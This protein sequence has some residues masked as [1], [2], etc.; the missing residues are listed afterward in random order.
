MTVSEIRRAGTKVGYSDQLDNN[1]KASNQKGSYARDNRVILPKS[2]NRRQSLP[3][4]HSGCISREGDIEL[5]I[6]WNIWSIH[7]CLEN[8]KQYEGADNQQGSFR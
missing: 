7:R 8:K 4:Q 6:C 3:P 2:P 5:A 1:G